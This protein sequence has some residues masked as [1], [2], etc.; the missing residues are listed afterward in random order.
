ME[1]RSVYKVAWKLKPADIHLSPCA[2]M[3][4]KPAARVLS[5]SCAI[6]KFIIFLVECCVH[7]QLYIEASLIPYLVGNP[8]GRLCSWDEE[9]EIAGLCL[10]VQNLHLPQAQFTLRPSLPIAIIS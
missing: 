2:K 4:V 8:W 6:C 9:V 1:A 10:C 5:R 3:S 7:V